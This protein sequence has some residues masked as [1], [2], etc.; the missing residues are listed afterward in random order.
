MCKNLLASQWRPA[1][2]APCPRSLAL[3]E[4]LGQ[5]A[6]LRPGMQPAKAAP[7]PNQFEP[8]AGM[9]PWRVPT[10]SLWRP[11]RA[12]SC[13]SGRLRRSP[14]R[15]RAAGSIPAWGEGAPVAAKLARTSGALIVVPSWA[16]RP[17]AL[18]PPTPIWLHL[19]LQN[20]CVSVSFQ[21]QVQPRPRAYK[22]LD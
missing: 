16:P 6:S 19:Q 1:A 8:A 7:C 21:G 5:E 14:L 13:R 17:S 2:P 9:E 15:G 11:S 4:T 12:R 20:G 18:P 3:G 10:S 22:V